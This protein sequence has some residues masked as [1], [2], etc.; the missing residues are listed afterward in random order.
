MVEFIIPAFISLIGI[1]LSLIVTSMNTN[2]Q[3]KNLDGRDY[4]IFIST[5]RIKWI[6]ELRKDFSQLYSLVSEN[7]GRTNVKNEIEIYYYISKLQLSLNPNGK[8]E[9]DIIKKLEKID[10]KIY[11]SEINPEDEEILIDTLIDL[12]K[13]FGMLFKEEWEK[14]KNEV[15]KE[16]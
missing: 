4:N 6:N 1:I 15:K 8:A 5:E 16:F 12:T 7:I 9:N 10:K 13:L 2:R 14:V 11:R 3:L